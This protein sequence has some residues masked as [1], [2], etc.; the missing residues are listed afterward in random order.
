MAQ[1]LVSS[2]LA[3]LRISLYSAA[4]VGRRAVCRIAA[5]EVLETLS[6]RSICLDESSSS[7]G[8]E[9]VWRNAKLAP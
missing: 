6:T 1:S 5:V 9:R 2:G 8:G 3:M 4:F 7:K